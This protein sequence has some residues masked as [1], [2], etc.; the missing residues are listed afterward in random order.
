MHQ[1]RVITRL[2][3]NALSHNVTTFTTVQPPKFVFGRVFALHA[4]FF[5]LGRHFLKV[6]TRMQVVF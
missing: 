6:M 1:A 2:L 4:T 5:V 3:P